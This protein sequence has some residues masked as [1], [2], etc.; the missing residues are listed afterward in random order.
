MDF[1]K[2]YP[3][4]TFED[5]FWGYSGAM[6]RLMSQ[7]GTSV[8]YLSEKQAAAYKSKKA[9]KVCSSVEEFAN[10]LGRPLK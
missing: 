2:Q 5:Y 4:M 10:A 6:I 9:K 3:S 1:I 8:R 7:D